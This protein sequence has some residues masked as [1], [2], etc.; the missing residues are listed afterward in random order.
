MKDRTFQTRTCPWCARATVYAPTNEAAIE[1]LVVHLKD[2]AGE[3]TLIPDTPAG[4]E[5]DRPIA[6]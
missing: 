2:C 5:R 4:L 6:N 3:Q 1:T